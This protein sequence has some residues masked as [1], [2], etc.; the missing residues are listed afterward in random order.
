MGNIVTLSYI[1][2]GDIDY[3]PQFG[4]IFRVDKSAPTS[5]NLYTTRIQAAKQ[6]S[7]DF[8]TL[9][10]GG[11]DILLDN[12]D[13]SM[14]ELCS[15]LKESNY[16]I[17]SI[18]EQKNGKRNKFMHHGVVCRTSEFNK[19]NI[20]TD[21]CFHFET[22]IYGLLSRDGIIYHDV[23]SYNWIPTSG[24]AAQWHDTPRARINSQRAISGLPPVIYSIPKNKHY[25]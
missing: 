21:G 8:F 11:E 16:N 14:R 20:P 2:L 7:T 25:M 3:I 1:V 10:D 17:G 5:A 6:I 12:F 9:L 22:L 18:C 19:L 24:G 15:K 13:T 4:S 23:E